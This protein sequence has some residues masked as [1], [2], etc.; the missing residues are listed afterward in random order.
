MD[1]SGP[2]VFFDDSGQCNCCMDALAR[3]PNEWW[4]TADGRTWLKS[5]IERIKK[6]MADRPYDVIIGLSGG[7][8]S[9]YVAHLLRR[10]FDLRIL[11]IH[12]DAGWNTEAAVHNI[13]LLVRKLDIDLYT[14]VVE[15]HE[16]RDLQLAYLKAS[17]LN[18]DAP[19]DHAF[20]SALYRLAKRYGQRYFLGG[21]NFSS[22]SVRIPEGGYPFEDARNLRA[23]HR[24]HG[25]LPLHSFPTIGSLEYLWL[26]RIRRQIRILKPLNYLP[27]DKEGAKRELVEAYGFVDYGS[28]H[29][30]SRFTKFYQEIYLPA[31]YGFDKRRLHCSA[32]IVSGQMTR[33]NALRELSVPATT[34]EQAARDKRFVAKKLGITVLELERLIAL[35]EV[36]HERYA[37]TQ[38]L[39]QM[40]RLLRKIVGGRR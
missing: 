32:L 29:Q 11:A 39:Y 16:M 5:T 31:R 14:H 24:A 2:G 34:K 13:E 21:M 18:Q 6:E 22:E 19:Q 15:W 4:P 9:A 25:S 35:P 20:F 17:V 3:K 8:D 1:N 36:R 33:D 37:N 40:N 7:V 23:I 38:A 28:K 26:S 12:V 27:Y 10:E 30:E